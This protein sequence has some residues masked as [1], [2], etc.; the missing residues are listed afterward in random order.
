GSMAGSDDL[1][2]SRSETMAGRYSRMVQDVVIEADRRVSTRHGERLN[3]GVGLALVLAD[4]GYPYQAT[5]VRAWMR[6]ETRP[7][8]DVFL[9]LAAKAGISLDERLG[10]GR[11]PTDLERQVADLR[12]T[13]EVLKSKVL[14]PAAGGHAPSGGA[15]LDDLL[16]RLGELEDQGVDLG[17]RLGRGWAGPGHDRDWWRRANAMRTRVGPPQARN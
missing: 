9:A 11:E 1:L 3:K 14:A 8:P 4:E 17:T 10:V 12:A 5:A 16:G 2:S 7:P 15:G 13:V 6:G